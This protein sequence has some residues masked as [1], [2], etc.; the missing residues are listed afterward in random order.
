M[1]SPRR[2]TR[3][4]SRSAPTAWSIRRPSTSTAR[5]ACSAASSSA[6]EK[7]ILD[8][9]HQLLRQTG[10]S[11]S[12][13]NAWVLLKGLET[14]PVRV[15]RQTENAAAVA[16]AL[17]GHKKMSRVHLSRPH[18]SS[19]G[20]HR[21][22]A[23]EGR[24]DAVFVRDQGRQGGAPSAFLNALQLDQ[25][26]QQS[27]R[28]QEPDHASDHDHAPAADAGAARRARHRRRAGAVL[29]RARAPRR[30]DRGSADGAGEGVKS[31]AA[32]PDRTRAERLSPTTPASRRLRRWRGSSPW[33]GSHSSSRSCA[34][35]RATRMP[36]TSGDRRRTSAS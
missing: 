20:R 30:P 7:F 18:G 19:A 9:D 34:A 13:F 26:H 10:P 12:P 27:R 36:K 23:D 14:L 3:A 32:I 24:L 25:H 2:S 35:R 17:A 29:G 21:Q 8:N 1:C 22:E 4:R 28:R 6:R 33:P 31:L 16:D 15:A 5:A 11:L